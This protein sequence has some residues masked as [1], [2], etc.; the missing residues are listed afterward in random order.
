LL[1]YVLV[2]WP[3][4]ARSGPSRSGSPAR[5]P[6]PRVPPGV[7]RWVG[8]LGL[9]LSLDEVQGPLSGTVPLS[10]VPGHPLDRRWSPDVCPRQLLCGLIPSPDAH[11]AQPQLRS[12]GLGSSFPEARLRASV[13]PARI[14]RDTGS[15]EWL[16]EGAVQGSGGF[17]FGC[18]SLALSRAGPW[19]PLWGMS[20]LG[21]LW[22]ESVR[23]TLG[24]SVLSTLFGDWSREGEQSWWGGRG[25]PHS[26][27][28]FPG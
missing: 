15:C 27:F 17:R 26:R 18:G 9:G 12:A 3:C 20:V 23:C 4:A 11:F 2:L 21:T 5:S 7:C 28:H 16:L 25:L 10:R 13:S 24:L 14:L 8:S 19:V 22:V 6:L 1:L